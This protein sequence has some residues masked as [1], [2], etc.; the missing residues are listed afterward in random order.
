MKKEDVIIQED[1]SSH[2]VLE[3]PMKCPPGSYCVH[4]IPEL[5]LETNY[6]ITFRFTGGGQTLYKSGLQNHTETLTT[7]LHVASTRKEDAREK[8]FD[9]KMIIEATNVLKLSYRFV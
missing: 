8:L 9:V 7:C 3:V 2:Y 1:E 6:T 4:V 5:E